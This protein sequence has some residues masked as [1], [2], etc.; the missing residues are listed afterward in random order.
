[1]KRVW[2][3]IGI[4][5]LAV[6]SCSLLSS[7]E[8]ATPAPSIDE[9]SPQ[10]SGAVDHTHLL[11]STVRIIKEVQ[12]GDE[13]VAIGAGSGTLIS[14]NGLIL[15]NAHI[16]SPA[17]RGES[18][19]PDRLTIAIMQSEDQPPVLLYVAR[20]VAVDGTLDMAVLQIDS[21]LNGAS[22]DPANLNL[23]YVELGNSDEVH[24]GDHLN[25][26]GFPGVGQDT[27]T[28]TQGSVAGYLADDPP[29]ERAWIKTDANIAHGN[30][31][32][33]V[34]NDNGEIIGIPT[35]G[36]GDCDQTDTD[37][38][39]QT[40]TCIPNGNAIN[41]IRPIN[42]A[43]PLIEAARLGEEYVSPYPQPGQVTEAGSGNE[44]AFDFVWVD[45]SN[46]IPET[47]RR[48]VD[49]V[50]S[51]PGSALCIAVEFEYSGMTSGER[52]RELWYLDGEVVVDYPFVWEDDAEGTYITY[53]PNNG[54]TM[55]AGEYYLELYAGEDERLIGTSDPVTVFVD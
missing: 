21:T 41:F 13:F 37:G 44:A 12:D 14:A 18:G 30:S 51:Y 36:L 23:P 24:I 31:G 6:L 2:I 17:S 4:L 20:L 25:V 3:A 19:E 15:T 45:T 48:E 22:V 8:V 47:C 10:S 34:A 29:G 33:L 42:F 1:M 16:A 52:V 55:P 7:S 27:I 40:D 11:M 5:S 26:Y 9:E 43:V 46:S 50:D 32:G 53:L 28:Y 35:S 49:F 54:E 39:G 38:D